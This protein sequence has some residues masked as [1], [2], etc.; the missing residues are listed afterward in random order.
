MT[1]AG[2]TPDEYQEAIK[3]VSLQESKDFLPDN[4]PK[5]PWQEA[6]DKFDRARNVSKIYYYDEDPEREREQRA[7]SHFQCGYAYLQAGLI[8]EAIE[9]FTVGRKLAPRDLRLA[10]AYSYALSLYRKEDKE[11]NKLA[12]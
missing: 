8:P 1:L 2:M 9:D 7:R 11:T 10:Q 5:Q 3:H 4:T 12:N 6:I